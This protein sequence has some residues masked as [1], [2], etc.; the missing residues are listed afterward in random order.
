MI[1]NKQFYSLKENLESN[2]P[3]GIKKDSFRIKG[4]EIKYEPFFLKGESKVLD[5]KMNIKHTITFSQD[6]VENI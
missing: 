2:N 1:T 5:I 6:L 4:K 3:D